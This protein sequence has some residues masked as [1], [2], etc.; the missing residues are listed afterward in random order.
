LPTVPEM[1]LTV[2]ATLTGEMARKLDDSFKEM[3]LGYTH[4]D[5][6]RPTIV[7]AGKEY[8]A[9][10]IKHLADVATKEPQAGIQPVIN[11]I[12]SVEGLVLGVYRQADDAV[13]DKKRPLVLALTEKPWENE[14]ERSSTGRMNV[15]EG[16][17]AYPRVIVTSNSELYHQMKRAAPDGIHVQL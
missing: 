9:A 15:I 2:T 8:E 7:H 14:K 1:N 5:G 3:M 6:Y 10:V 12:D 11:S 17:A 4:I 16:L 13:V